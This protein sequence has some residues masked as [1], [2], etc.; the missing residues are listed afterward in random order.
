MN[1]PVSKTTNLKLLKLEIERFRGDSKEYKS[2][3]DSF[4][5]AVNR[6][7]DIAE[8]EK[9]I[10]LKSFLNGNRFSQQRT[11]KKFYTF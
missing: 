11:L 1:N 2:F 7:S 3:K 9:F 10:Y 8:V 4:E 6:I 5:I